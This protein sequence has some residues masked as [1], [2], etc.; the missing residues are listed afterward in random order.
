M[1]EKMVSQDEFLREH[2]EIDY[3]FSLPHAIVHSGLGPEVRL[4]LLVLSAHTNS[5]GETDCQTDEEL[6][7]QTGLDLHTVE[8]AMD[9]ARKNGWV[10]DDPKYKDEYSLDVGMFRVEVLS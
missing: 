5:L 2:P 10:V 8:W 4:V 1:S 3:F 7:E 6:A 9:A